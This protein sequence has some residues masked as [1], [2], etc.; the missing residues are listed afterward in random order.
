PASSTGARRRRGACSRVPRRSSQ[1]SRARRRQSCR[2][3]QAGL[4]LWG[5]RGERECCASDRLREA[6]IGALLLG[7]AKDKGFPP[8]D[9]GAV[10]FVLPRMP[11]VDVPCGATRPFL[12]IRMR[13]AGSA[14]LSRDF[15]SA[16]GHERIAVERLVERPFQAPLVVLGQRE[17][18]GLEVFERYEGHDG[19]SILDGRD[20]ASRSAAWAVDRTGRGKQSPQSTRPGGPFGLGRVQIAASSI[21]RPSG[22]NSVRN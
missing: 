19:N 1:R 18:G 5:F 9:G 20:A 3:R 10:G 17:D 21:C 16:D 12:E 14:E 4:Y 22:K 15:G 11:G 8:V 6:Q 7:V 13:A 2:I